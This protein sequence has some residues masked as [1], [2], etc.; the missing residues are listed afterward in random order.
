MALVGAC[1]VEQK[2]SKNHFGKKRNNMFSFMDKYPHKTHVYTSTAQN[3]WNSV[4]IQ[5]K[6]F[7]QKVLGFLNVVCKLLKFLISKSQFKNKKSNLMIKFFV[8]CKL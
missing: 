5:T 4:V 3:H 2:N 1:E 7:K 8:F 6:K